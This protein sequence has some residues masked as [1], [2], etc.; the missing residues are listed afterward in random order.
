[1]CYALNIAEKVV[2]LLLLAGLFS[3]GSATARSYTGQSNNAWD[4][5]GT[6]S[7]HLN[8]LNGTNET[9]F[10]VPT[11][12]LFDSGIPLVINEFMAS[13]SSNS[14]ISDP[15]GEFDDWIE[16]YN[17]GDTPIDMSGMYLTD[18]LG[19]PVKWQFPYDNPSVTTIPAQGYMLIWLDGDTD[20]TG[21]H[22]SFKLSRDGEEIGLF[23][24]DGI[25]LVSS[26]SF[27]QQVAG[28]SYG[29]YPDASAHWGFIGEPT[30]GGENNSGFLGVV[31]DTKFSIDRG[32]YDEPF[33]VEI[34]TETEDAVIL[35]TLNGSEPDE[36]TGIVYT[37]PIFISTTSCLRAAA[38]KEGWLPTNVDTHTYIFLDDVLNQPNNPGGF[39]DTW[40]V[41]VYQNVG[42]PVPADYGMDP[43]IAVDRASLES[44]PSMSI[45]MENN[46]LF[47]PGYGIYS[48]PT[49]RHE[50]TQGE[51]WE[52]AASLEYIDPNGD[53]GFQVNCGIRIQGGWSRRP[54]QNPKHSFRVLFKNEY[55][56][57]HLEFPLFGED[58]SDSINCIAL[59]GGFNDS[60]ATGH[61]N[62]Q[63]IRD[64]W[65]RNTQRA[66]GHLSSH[67]T[68]VHLYING[69]YWG[70]YNPVE[71]PD[72]H[73]MAEYFGGDEDDYDIFNHNALHSPDNAQW[74]TGDDR[75]PIDGNFVAWDAMMD[76]VDAGVNTYE[77]YQN[78]QEYL[79]IHNFIDHVIYNH[80]IGCWTWG[81][82]NFYIGRK[83]E[84][85]EGFK[86]FSWDAEQSFFSYNSD[87]GWDIWQKSHTPAHL[88][89]AMK[90]NTEF[91]VDFADRLHKYMFN[92]G[93]LTS[94]SG[95]DRWIALD[96][97]IF[98][99]LTAE[100]GRWD[101]VPTRRDVH[102]VN[103]RN[104]ILARFFPRR[105]AWA[106]D[107][108][109]AEGLYPSIEA[110]IFY[111][112][113]FYQHGGYVSDGAVLM[114][115][116]PGS[117]TIYYS[118]DGSDPR[119]DMT[120]VE[121]TSIT[122]IA[123]DAENRNEPGLTPGSLEY[124]GPVTLN[125][126][127]NVKARVFNGSWSALNEAVFDVEYADPNT[128]DDKANWR[129][130]ENPG[131]T[132]GDD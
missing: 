93:L 132:P 32:F 43:S 17:D 57:S 92:D 99:A 35:Y 18:D 67:G 111:I 100:M 15:Q 121:D 4:Y 8:A 120:S 50:P 34:T 28:I 110:P 12:Y 124:T 77:Q 116:N 105:T 72:G 122:L 41:Y 23:D 36:S 129:A 109:R 51:D 123:E 74:Y 98:P 54:S 47:D 76:I 53:P 102:Y 55:G 107:R 60:W 7:V 84:P 3:A 86:F 83:R 31:S 117:G 113:G 114:I 24:S 9:N 131:G 119:S 130:S 126:S 115:D 127:V 108:F 29:R 90:N 37:D 30:P 39:P 73:F 46:D 64:E 26:I 20:D 106:L 33:S 103:E 125:Q 27:N 5:S 52:R 63:Y 80:Y 95:Q 91:R 49:K 40:G 81:S 70:L 62:A 61:S 79:D 65:A 66:M 78:I 87:N 94:Q 25:T 11:E 59:R 14:G 104:R 96:E 118:L 88:F 75:D 56:P 1:M 42:N 112:D 89:S 128:W 48:N 45:V 68:W 6:D 58:A 82:W 2:P 16:I 44:L 101:N 71:R 97:K 85:N 13:N 19:E 69:L 38:F 10:A 22:A 21:L